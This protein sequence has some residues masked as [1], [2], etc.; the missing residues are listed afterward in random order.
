MAA[1]ATIPSARWIMR[2]TISGRGLEVKALH[3][4]RRGIGDPVAVRA[5]NPSRSQIILQIRGKFAP[6]RPDAPG[7]PLRRLSQ[8]IALRP[9]VSSDAERLRSAVGEPRAARR[10]SPG[11]RLARLGRCPAERGESRCEVG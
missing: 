2:T 5:F 1:A 11:G 7:D 6:D 4:R 10:E 3:V 8:G 9:P